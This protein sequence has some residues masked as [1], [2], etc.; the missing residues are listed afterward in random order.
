LLSEHVTL[1]QLLGGAVIF[2]SM[3]LAQ[4]KAASDRAGPPVTS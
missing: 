1:V 2:G 4:S 3:M